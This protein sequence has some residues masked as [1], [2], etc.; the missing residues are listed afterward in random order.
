LGI[1]CPRTAHTNTKINIPVNVNL[2]RIIIS[3]W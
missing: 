1:Y 3:G 2:M